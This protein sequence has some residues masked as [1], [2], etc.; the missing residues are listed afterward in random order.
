MITIDG[1]QG[2][3]GG[4]ILRTSLALSVV[5]GQPFH[6]ERIRARRS[7]PGLARQHLVA[8]QAAAA[9][10]HAEVQGASLRSMELVFRPGRP[11]PGNYRFDIGTAGST[12]LVIQTILPALMLSPGN[13]EVEL[14]GGTHNPLA[15]PIDFLQ[16]TFCPLLQRM[17]AKVEIRLERPGFYPAGGGRVVLRVEGGGGL[18]PL[19]LVGRGRLLRRLLWAA[20]ANLPQHIAQREVDSL[21]NRLGFGREETAVYT[22]QAFGPG[23]VVAVEL[24]FEEITELFTN[25]GQ[26]GKP[27]E[28]VAEELAAEVCQYLESDV[29]VGPHLADQILL[30]L[31]LA[32]GG[33]FRTLPLTSHAE[34]NLAVIGQFL[35][36]RWEVRQEGD[37][38][39]EVRIGSFCG[40]SW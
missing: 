1:S 8:V 9:I 25:F 21:R 18:R 22:W 28:E 11:R 4:Q 20:V 3:G 14:V 6:M 15:P 37:R 36:L 31:A 27:A 32:G 34:T 12:S 5:T 40:S 13:W 26:R 39:C 7:K 33:R 10:C 35:P 30:P 17:G 2:E 29:P 38:A 24:E 16:R 23:N 19:E